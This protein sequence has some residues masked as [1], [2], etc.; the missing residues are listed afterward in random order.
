[1]AVADTST[2][3]KIIGSDDRPGLNGQ[4]PRRKKRH[5]GHSEKGHDD[6]DDDDIDCVVL[7]G[8]ERSTGTVVQPLQ[9]W[10]IFM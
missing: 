2:S 10:N 4:P 8:D 5:F 7:K 3:K 9:R 1:M 6:D